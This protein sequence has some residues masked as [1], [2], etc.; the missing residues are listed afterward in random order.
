LL[1]RLLLHYLLPYESFPLFH[2]R[3][4]LPLDLEPM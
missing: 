3:F 1:L 4:L 2:S